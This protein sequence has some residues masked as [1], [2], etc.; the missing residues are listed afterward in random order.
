MYRRLEK[1]LS[2]HYLR[3]SYEGNG[4][5]YY[6][7]SGLCPDDNVDTW[8]MIDVVLHFLKDY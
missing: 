8:T 6:R 3:I 4:M 2:G 7:L 5:W 1:S